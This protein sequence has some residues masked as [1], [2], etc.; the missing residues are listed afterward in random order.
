[1]NNRKI[2]LVKHMKAHGVIYLLCLPGI[3]WLFMFRLIP[4]AGSVIA[5][6]DYS[7]FKGLLKSPWVGLENFKT[8]LSYSDFTRI[9]KNTVILGLYTVTLTFPLP[10]IMALLINE[11][12]NFHVKKGIQ[13][14]LY[15]PHFFS[16]V[17]IAGFF[18]SFLGENG[19]LNQLRGVFG[20]EPILFI[21]Y[22][23]YFRAIVTS[24]AIYRETG[25]GTIIFLAAIAG[26]DPGLYEA[27]IMDGA[28]KFQ[29]MVYITIP[30]ILPTIVV[31]LLLRIGQFM[32]LGFDR[33]YQFLTPM[34]FS[35]GDIFDTYVFRVGISG[36]QYSLSTA[37]GI[38]QSIVG[39]ILVIGFNKLVKKMNGEGVY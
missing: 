38:F 9:L 11:V 1:M 36:A 25:W 10:I 28:S 16:W 23:Q 20:F 7:I 37:I 8:L 30:S 14:I 5:F 29:R 31:L 18:F 33:I 13:T 32:N 22:K 34:T 15:I 35:V 27:A 6:Q 26:I 24:A 21:Q 12:K 19:I 17:I 4:I 39:L 2:Q 3:I